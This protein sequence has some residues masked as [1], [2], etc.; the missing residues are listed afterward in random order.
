MKKLYVGNLPYSYN[1][2]KLAE[3]FAEFGEVESAV[4]IIDRTRN[5]SKG[6]GFVEI[7]DA[8]AEKAMAELNDKEIDGRVLKI[9]EARPMNNE[10]RGDFSRR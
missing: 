8:G 2:Q 4:V 7:D 3:L 6:F 9:S 5:R 10:R 1:D